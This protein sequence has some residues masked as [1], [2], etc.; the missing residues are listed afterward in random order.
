ML[1]GSIILPNDV[2]LKSNA[3][4]PKLRYLFFALI[5]SFK[6]NHFEFLDLNS[7]T[8]DNKL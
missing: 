3:Y 2:A 6:M 7:T 4:Q 8:C 1:A 5:C